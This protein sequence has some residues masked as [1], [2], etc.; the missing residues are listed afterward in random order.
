MVGIIA[1]IIALIV[2]ILTLIEE[3]HWSK[4]GNRKMFKDKYDKWN[5]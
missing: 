5:L 4:I 1:T 3:F 2:I